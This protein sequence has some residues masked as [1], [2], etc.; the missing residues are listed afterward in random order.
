[1][2]SFPILGPKTKKLHTMSWWPAPARARL[3]TP[4]S[5]SVDERLSWTEPRQTKL[6]EDLAYSLLGIFDVNI[7][8]HYGDGKINAFERLQKEIDKLE[9]CMQDLYLTDPQDDKKRIV[10][11]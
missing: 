7:P 6:E 11:T 9:K 3:A 2:L 10:L 5:A 8:L 1:M 4:K